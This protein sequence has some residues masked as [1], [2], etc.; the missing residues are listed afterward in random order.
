MKQYQ[1]K[2][3]SSILFT[4]F[5][6]HIISVDNMSNANHFIRNYKFKVNYKY[7]IEFNSIRA[8]H[9]EFMR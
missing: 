7:F 2:R 4:V 9:N 6:I 1:A 8:D 3:M 5:L